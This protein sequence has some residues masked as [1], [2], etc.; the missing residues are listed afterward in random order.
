MLT[1]TVVKKYFLSAVAV[2]FMVFAAQ[3]MHAQIGAGNVEL[4]FDSQV[5][6][7]GYPNVTGPNVSANEP[8]TA[9][10][11]VNGVTGNEGTTY[12]SC[13]DSKAG[14]IFSWS[15]Q[16]TAHTTFQFSPAAGSHAMYCTANYTG[17]HV[18]GTAT[19]ATISFAAD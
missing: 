3:A 5:A 4:T 16:V 17:E 14:L 2:L 11:S 13:Y 1:L 10:I 9:G 15:T 19:T 8:L 6:Y 7:N 12:V 18:N